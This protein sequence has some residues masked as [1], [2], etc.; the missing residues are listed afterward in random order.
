MADMKDED[1]H[2]NPAVR[3]SKMALR[4][5]MGKAS[6]KP[7]HHGHG[8]VVE[9]SVVKHKDGKAHVRARHEDGHEAI[10]EHPNHE[11][12]QAHASA[13]MQPG[14]ENQGMPGLNTP[15]ENEDA[16]AMMGGEPGGTN[17]EGSAGGEGGETCPTC[18]SEMHGDSCPNC[19]YKK[20]EE[21]E[22]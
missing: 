14:G 3:R 16:N 17:P 9:T 4:H 1:Y 6:S 13:L 21:G 5:S 22:E 11:A 19:G 18:G 10:H 7:E 2:P 20:D 12:A 15:A 8:P